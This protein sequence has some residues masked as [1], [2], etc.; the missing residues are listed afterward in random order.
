MTSSIDSRATVSI[1]FQP[2]GTSRLSSEMR[3]GIGVRSTRPAEE[4]K[5]LACKAAVS[6]PS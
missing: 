2:A 3:L 5:F 6:T 1:L 4:G